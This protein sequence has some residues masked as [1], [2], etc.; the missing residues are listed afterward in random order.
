MTVARA[1]SANRKLWLLVALLLIAFGLR[2][3]QL[4][5]QS[6]WSDEGLS[7]YRARL[8]LRE[9]LT[10]VIVVPPGVPTLD[11]NPPLYFVALG[12]LRAVAGESE[13]A[14]RFVSVLAGVLLVPLLYVTGKRLF[15][16]QAGLLA[17][18]LGTV[19]PF[20][21]WYAQEARMYT[22]L[23]TLS[24]AS[25]YLLLRAIDWPA[26]SKN[27]RSIRPL[28]RWLIWI[29][30]VVVTTAAL[31]THFTAFF[32][33]MFEGAVLLMALIRRRRREVVI[34]IALLA[35]LALPLTWYAISRAQRSADPGFGFRPLASIVA[36]VWGTFVVA[37]TNDLFQPW[38]A[39]LPAL[40]LFA[41]GLFGGVLQ[42]SLRRAT[43]L[44][45]LYL[46]VPLLAFYAVTFVRPLYTGPR[47]LILLLPPIYLLVASGLALL[48]RQMRPAATV[49]LTA[50]L[51]IVGWWLHV[52]WTDPAYLKDDMRSA[53]CTIA[54]QATAD[55]VV[56]VHDA[57]TSYVFDYYY[58][59]CGGQAPWKII[60]TYPA[61]DVE[62]ALRDFQAE[63][64]QAAR[65]W[66]VTDPRPLSG[67]D[68]A[69]L[70]VW[71][72]GHLLRLGHEKF[73]SI[74]L[75]SAYQLYTAHFPIFATLPLNAEARTVLWPTDRLHL[76][77]VDPIVI[78]PGR[79]RARVNLYWRLDQPV[80]RNFNFTAR[81]VDRSGAEWGLFNG[82]AFDNWS[83]KNWPV[84][85]F[86]Q[87]SLEMELP[88][89]LPPGD[90]AL[91]LSAADRQTNETIPVS[92]GST[93]VEVAAVKVS[94]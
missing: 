92:D 42:K 94:P 56:I 77:G 71:A 69:A 43:V 41:I 68:P 35:V 73:H 44:V 78:A 30:W 13:Y 19:S 22:L 66:F 82:S 24:L 40:L 67:F 86:I 49:A 72:R 60:P 59:R 38:W 91:R 34:I 10:N 87:Q 12:M 61:H 90:Y 32:L 25:V 52:Q 37:R 63:A 21:V 7:L 88:N 2:V 20:L 64:N 17:A 11:T 9:N 80:Q 58:Q 45:A 93:E 23:A 26:R 15:S 79:D 54:A 18:L 51:I 50:V 8:S 83:A 89:G 75:G 65:V 16:E 36:E 46:F 29:A 55:D 3:Y 31:Y 33:L 76:A 28:H 5:A 85:Q 39:V 27:T 53:A 47:H 48:W 81:L 62:V 57:I 4:P 6:L 14:L 84:G 70:D 74:W 1:S